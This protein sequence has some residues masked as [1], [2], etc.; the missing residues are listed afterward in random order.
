MLIFHQNY[1]IFIAIP[2]VLLVLSVREKEEGGGG[3][4]SMITT[5][6]YKCMNESNA[7]KV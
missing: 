3:D 2:T 1:L 6:K 4:G 5:K 7:R